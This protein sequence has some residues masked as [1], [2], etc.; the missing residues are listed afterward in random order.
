[1]EN[2]FVCILVSGA[3]GCAAPSAEWFMLIAESGRVHLQGVVTRNMVHVNSGVREGS[4]SWRSYEGCATIIFKNTKV[5]FKVRK[6]LDIQPIFT[7]RITAIR[8]GN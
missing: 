8:H 2:M 7:L 6:I 5:F 4:P 3:C 1:M